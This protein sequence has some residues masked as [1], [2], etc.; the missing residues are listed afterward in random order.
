MGAP[1]IT[2]NF[3]Y[4]DLRKLNKLLD[5]TYSLAINMRNPDS[6][7]FLK[8][9]D[10]KNIYFR[11]FVELFLETITSDMLKKKKGVDELCSRFPQEVAILRKDKRFAEISYHTISKPFLIGIFS[12]HAMGMQEFMKS[13]LEFCVN[14]D[15]SKQYRDL[16]PT[17]RLFIYEQWRKSK[18]EQSLYF[19]TDGFY[20][21]FFSVI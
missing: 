3:I 16:S 5:E 11:F 4:Y 1:I 6:N 14:S 17:E 8:R 15:D 20:F 7:Y 13:Q 18:G 12:L 9:A 2:S 10:D 21:L 19:E